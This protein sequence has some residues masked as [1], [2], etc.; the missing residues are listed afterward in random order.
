M[1]SAFGY[2]SWGFIRFGPVRLGWDGVGG[3]HYLSFC[4][5]VNFMKNNEKSQ[6]GGGSVFIG[7]G[8]LGG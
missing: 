3:F 4:F 2:L 8:P 6:R 1:I 7:F 5:F